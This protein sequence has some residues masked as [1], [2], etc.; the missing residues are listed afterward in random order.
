MKANSYKGEV[1]PDP[2]QLCAKSRVISLEDFL[3]DK[4]FYEREFSFF[5]G[6][7][8]FSGKLCPFI[9]KSKPEKNQKITQ[10]LEKTNVGVGVYLPS[11]PD[12]VVTDIDRKSASSVKAVS[13]STVT[14]ELWQVAIFK[15][16]DD[17][18]QNVL[19]LQLILAFQN[20]FDSVG[21]VFPYGSLQPLLDVVSLTSCQIPYP[22]ICWDEAMKR[23][24]VTT[25]SISNNLVKSTAAYSVISYLLRFKVVL[26]FDSGL[27][28]F[29]PET[30]QNFKD[31]FVLDKNVRGAADYMRYLIKKSFRSYSTIQ[32]DSSQHL[33]KGIPY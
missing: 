21:L 3:A 15:I 22:E 23:D 4:S 9:K 7:T 6:V 10:E 32:Y 26:T 11:N 17:C 25:S 24:F 31:S 19:A 12:G 27:Y 33:T 29:K 5:N 28:C 20:I 30:I 13:T 2:I 1:K 14:K 8:L 18:R 16:G